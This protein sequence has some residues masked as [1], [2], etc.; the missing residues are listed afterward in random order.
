MVEFIEKKEEPS[1]LK[2]TPE[3]SINEK[4][5]FHHNGKQIVETTVSTS[6]QTMDK[7]SSHNFS[8]KGKLILICHFCRNLWH[9]CSNCY[10]MNRMLGKYVYYSGQPRNEPRTKIDLTTSFYNCYYYALMTSS[11]MFSD[12]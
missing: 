7:N 1:S 8:R 11:S 4:S 9:I 10:R 2:I 12:D 3:G 5:N 6:N